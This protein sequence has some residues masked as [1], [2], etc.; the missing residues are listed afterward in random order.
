MVGVKNKTVLSAPLVT[1][2]IASRHKVRNLARFCRIARFAC[3]MVK[4][5]QSLEVNKL[6][7]NIKNQNVK[8]YVNKM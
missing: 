3:V 2:F 8:M 5:E 1:T 4:R 6:G 7:S